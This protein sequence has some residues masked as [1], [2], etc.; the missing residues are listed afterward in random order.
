MEEKTIKRRDLLAVALS[1]SF[2][3]ILSGGK[4]FG[5]F[6]SGAASYILLEDGTPVLLEDGTQLLTE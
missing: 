1:G 2:S 6:S 3:P 5:V 4:P